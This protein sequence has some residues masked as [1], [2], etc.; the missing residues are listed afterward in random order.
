MTRLAPVVSLLLTCSLAHGFALRKSD[1]GKV[2]CLG[3]QS[4]TV[5]ID[6]STVS[7]LGGAADAVQAGFVAW[8]SAG[9]PATV[10][11]KAQKNLKLAADGKNSV[12]WQ[13]GEWLYSEHVVA[14][15]VTSY[16]RS[17]GR[18]TESDIVLNARD[19][20]WAVDPAPGSNA[21]DVQ[22]VVAHEA[23]HFFGLGH[24][25]QT[26]ATMYRTTPAEETQKRVL[27]ADDRAGIAALIAVI[28]ATGGDSES[29]V[30]DGKADTPEQLDGDMPDR[31]DEQVGCSVG[32][33]FSSAGSWLWPS[34]VLGLG[35]LLR[36]RRVAPAV[37]F[38]AALLPSAPV[39]ASVVRQLSLAQ[40]H[41]E[42]AAV[43]R[44]AV[45]ARR[46]FVDP[47]TNLIVTDHTIRVSR[48]FKR[49]AAACQASVTLQTL[50]GE[51][52]DRGVHVEGMPRLAVGQQVILFGRR[53]GARLMPVGLSLGVFKLDLKTRKAV[54]DLRGLDLLRGGRRVEGGLERVDIRTLEAELERLAP[55]PTR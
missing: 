14:M 24:S 9:M 45:T 7:Q 49:G 4:V 19:H 50:G 2:L 1:D 21:Y 16:K 5:R 29:V 42:S 40:L 41:A 17:T 53:A 8:T 37:A 36:C 54:R 44:G 51:V 10:K 46:S 22:N 33:S 23:G 43:V 28:N 11:F 18:V 13:T 55:K 35:L 3:T 34:L 48:C 25:A 30:D 12:L 52:G 27:T 47:K 26:D 31:G 6:T 20:K 32:G 15:T 38:V 39:E